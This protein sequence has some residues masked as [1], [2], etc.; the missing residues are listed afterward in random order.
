MSKSQASSHWTEKLDLVTERLG[1]LPIA[2]HF[3]K[4]LG[5]DQ[6]FERF[7]VEQDRR[8][9]VQ[10]AKGLGV[11]LRSLV[12]E[13]EPIYRHYEM[14]NT[15]ASSHFGLSG[16]EAK[17]LNDDQLGRALD[18]LYDADRGSLLTELVVTAAHEFDV[19]LEE[20]HNDS[21]TVKFTGQYRLA[22]GRSIRGKRAPWIRFG[23]S[24]DHRP[25]LKQLL[26]VMTTSS[27]GG[28]PFQFRCDDGN[29]S[30][31]TTHIETWESL[32]K[33]I[34]T[35]GFLYVGDSKLCSFDTMHH[36]DRHQGRLVTVMPRSRFEDEHFRKWIQNN[37]PAWELVWD[38]PNPRS[39]YGPRDRW[40]VYK[41][42]LPSQ[43]AWPVIWVWS[44]LLSLKQKRSRHERIAA[45]QEKLADLDR[46]LEG[47]RPRRRSHA[48]IAQSVEE[49]TAR[50]KVRKYLRTEVWYEEL[51]SFRQVTRGRPSSHTRY[52][53]IV[54]H[55]PRIRWSLHQDVIDYDEKSDGMYPLLTNDR[56]LTP[57]QVLEAH[58][59]QP[60]I[61][62]RFQQLKTVLEIAPVLLKSEA[63]IEAF[64]FLFFVSLLIHSLIEREARR[65]MKREN[66][67]AIPIYPE[68]R[69]SSRP[70]ADQILRLFSLTEQHSLYKDGRLV[71][72]FPP[73]LTDIHRLV[74]HL[75]GV[76]PST[77]LHPS[78]PSRN[79]RDIPLEMCGM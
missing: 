44:T 54:K 71:R 78:L 75:L 67:D 60:A 42:S 34:G 10:P 9:V 39:K 43:E 70:T 29:T 76:S 25:D 18:R 2:N 72:V 3:I 27:D 53:R 26:L 37:Q 73:A 41:A 49:I 13:R 57:R 51:E 33:A 45:A 1:P 31:S 19:C 55:R 56:S 5:V 64:F 14:V 7:V 38:R 65:A 68:Q 52:K 59:R 63:R 66:I 11:L 12:V 24:K 47:P 28:I 77:Y 58:K 15:F 6:L 22:K 23:F 16:E 79:S 36:I 35:P 20:L 40:L 21:T 61:E 48:Q 32:V 50:F 4:R 69:P 46:R 8:C 74:L 17:R 30:D 62:K